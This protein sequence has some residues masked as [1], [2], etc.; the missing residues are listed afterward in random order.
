MGLTDFTAGKKLRTG[1][2]GIL[3]VGLLAFVALLAAGCGGGEAK[4]EATVTV[5]TGGRLQI[6]ETYYDF[7]K[8]PVGQWAE[9][10]FELKNTG[11]GPLNLGQMAVKRL[12]GC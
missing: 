7:D 8:V 6:V 4:T 9:H 2:F 3:A 10:N 12:E 1:P 5:D 11:T